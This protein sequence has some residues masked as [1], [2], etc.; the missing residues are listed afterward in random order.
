MHLHRETTTAAWNRLAGCHQRRHLLP[1]M[2]GQSTC[3]HAGGLVVIARDGCLYHCKHDGTGDGMAHAIIRLARHP[4][5]GLITDRSVSSWR[6]LFRHPSSFSMTMPR[7]SAA[8]PTAIWPPGSAPEPPRQPPLLRDGSFTTRCCWLA[9]L[10]TM[11]QIGTQM[12]PSICAF[13]PG[14]EIS[15]ELT[16]LLQNKKLSG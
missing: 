7:D 11:V 9:S 3:F 10:I 2:C 13:S 6:H 8:S 4:P 12:S 14:N 1:I 15:R 5:I 16:S